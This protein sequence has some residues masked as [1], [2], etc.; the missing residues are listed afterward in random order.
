MSEM[1]EY[2]TETGARRMNE[3]IPNEIKWRGSNYLLVS[4]EGERVN[5]KNPVSRFEGSCTVESWKK[6]IPYEND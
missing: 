3:N 2:K 1:S 4:V 5:W 6:S